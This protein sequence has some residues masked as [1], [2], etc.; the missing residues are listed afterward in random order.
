MEVLY[1]AGSRFCYR[2]LQ[3]YSLITSLVSCYKVSKLVGNTLILLI[4]SGFICKHQGS[5][6]QSLSSFLWRIWYRFIL[7]RL[8]GKDCCK[9]GR[10]LKQCVR[11]VLTRIKNSFVKIFKISI[12]RQNS[13]NEYPQ[14]F[15]PHLVQC[16]IYFS[17]L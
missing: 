14:N 9:Q 7:S 3:I 1:L 5:S 13:D 10:I 16:D 2:E 8:Q 12:L 4:E 6:E 17:N 11:D 15:Q